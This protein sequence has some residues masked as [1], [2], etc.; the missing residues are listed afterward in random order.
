MNIPALLILKSLENDDKEICKLFY[1]GMFDPTS[2]KYILVRNMRTL[3]TKLRKMHS[4]YEL[5]NL[6]EKCIIEVSLSKDEL[7][8]LATLDLERVLLKDI[9]RLAIELSRNSPADWNKFLDVVLS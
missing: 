3:F 7:L 4:R 9:R 2:E 6:M 8:Q 5:Y 1:P